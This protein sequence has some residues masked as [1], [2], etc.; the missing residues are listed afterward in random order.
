MAIIAPHIYE[1]AWNQQYQQLV[2]KHQQLAQNLSAPVQMYVNSH[3][4]SLQILAST[5]NQLPYQD[6]AQYQRLVYQSV[7]YLD[8]FNARA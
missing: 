8:G 7:H 5:I 1:T 4:Q 2:E 3:R 6:L